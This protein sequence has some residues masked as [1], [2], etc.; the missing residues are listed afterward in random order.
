MHIEP[1]ELHQAILDLSGEER[2][3]IDIDEDA[4]KRI[5]LLRNQ[6]RSCDILFESYIGK[7]IDESNQLNLERFIETYT[8]LRMKRE[9]ETRHAVLSM[10]GTEAFG[11][12]TSNDYGFVINP[13]IN[14]II[15]FKRD[16]KGGE[17]I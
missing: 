1:S 5:T 2:I 7:T 3:F 16:K 13:E 12:V 6:I 17:Q 8:N 11:L 15:I 9:E 10:I 4:C 14:K